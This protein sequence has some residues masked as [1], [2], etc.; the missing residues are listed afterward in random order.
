MHRGRSWRLTSRRSRTRRARPVLP[1]SCSLR[2]TN[3]FLPLSASWRTSGNQRGGTDR[4]SCKRPRCRRASQSSPPRE[5]YAGQIK[6]HNRTDLSARSWLAASHLTSCTLG[7][8]DQLPHH[9][10]QRLDICG[11]LPVVHRCK[12]VP[13]TTAQASRMMVAWQAGRISR[14]AAS[15]RDPPE[16]A[17]GRCGDRKHGLAKY[18]AASFMRSCTRLIESMV[19]LTSADADVFR[20]DDRNPHDGRPACA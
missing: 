18:L 9:G 3:T 13:R 10:L 15:A 17:A 7:N 11:M 5:G 8:V 4:R 20:R 12:P 16:P 19:F 14:N 2:S 6:S 1:M